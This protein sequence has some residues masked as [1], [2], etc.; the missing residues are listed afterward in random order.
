MSTEALICPP[1]LTEEVSAVAEPL[2]ALPL[3]K[4][5]E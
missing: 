2:I 5:M 1:E 4:A 3:T